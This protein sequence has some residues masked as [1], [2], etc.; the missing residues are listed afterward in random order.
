MCRQTQ[1]HALWS[2][3]VTW[4]QVFS[5]RFV[6]LCFF[7]NRN[8]FLWGQDGMKR[9]N[10]PQCS[11]QGGC[12]RALH[13]TGGGLGVLPQ[14]NFANI[15]YEK[16]ILEQFWRPQ[17]KK[18]AKKGFHRDWWKKGFS[19]KKKVKKGLKGFPVRPALNM[20]C[21]ISNGLGHFIWPWRW[22]WIINFI[23]EMDSGDR[24][25]VEKLHYMTL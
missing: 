13:A 18:K 17:G 23:S 3:S 24:N 1:R 25:H 10:V 4:S 15:S 14:E 5:Q 19:L 7:F 20:A 6:I 2:G 22:P 21:A 12:R 8:F 9:C 11:A 16:G